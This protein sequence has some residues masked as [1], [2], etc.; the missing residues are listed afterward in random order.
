MT[1]RGDQPGRSYT[2]S[3]DAAR[4]T[5]IRDDGAVMVEISPNLFVEESITERLGLLR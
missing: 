2:T 1:P 5:C 4:K 3:R